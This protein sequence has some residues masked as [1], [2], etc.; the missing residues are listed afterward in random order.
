MDD[1][2]QGELPHAAEDTSHS[3]PSTGGQMP[4][5][6]ESSKVK[7]LS[8]RLSHDGTSEKGAQCSPA[9]DKNHWFIWPQWDL[10]IILFIL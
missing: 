7:N 5:R 9:W 10:S 6:R 1:T 4:A 8:P 2:L 3:L